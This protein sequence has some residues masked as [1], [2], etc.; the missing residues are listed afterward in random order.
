MPEK[1]SPSGI[2][3]LP[4]PET[5]TRVEELAPGPLG[6]SRVCQCPNKVICDCSFTRSP[7]CVQCAKY[8]KAPVVIEWKQEPRGREEPLGV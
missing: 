4:V 1:A 7:H 8:F 5:P 2:Q 3:T 6:I